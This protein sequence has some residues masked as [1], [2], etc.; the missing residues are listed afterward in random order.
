MGASL[1][2]ATFTS[3][4]AENKDSGFLR[5]YS[6]LEETSTAGGATIRAWASPKFR[7]DTYTAV[8]I[9]PLVIYPE[10]RPSERVT[11]EALHQIVDYANNRIQ[12]QFR[13]E[14]EV[15]N[16]PGPGVARLRVAI[17]SVASK[18]EG[19]KPYQ[20]VPIALV[21]T[22]A[23]R[24][25]KGGAPQR[26]LIVMEVEVSDSVTGELLAARV[27]SGTGERLA[28]IGDKEQITLDVVKPFLNELVKDIAPELT[29]Y[30]KKK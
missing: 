19:L 4:I 25:M 2:V 30:I 16:S 22:M 1:G 21:A 6:R 23:S 13:D 27:R 20:L 29:T 28:Q 10:P 24:S 9:D 26:A 7:P 3:A 12:R 11:A 15:V 17:T 8:M 14:V 5:D 18:D